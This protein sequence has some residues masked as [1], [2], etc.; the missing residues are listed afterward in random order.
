M[1]IAVNETMEHPARHESG[2]RG[3]LAGL[4]ERFTLGYERR[5]L[6][7]LLLVFVVDYADRT[8]ISSLGPTLERVYHLNNTQLGLV[9]A[10]FSLVAVIVSIPLGMLTDRIRRT[11]LFA[12]TLL[13]WAVAEVFVGAAV[14]FLMFFLVRLALGAVAATT[15]PTTPSMVGDL[16][17]AGERGRAFGFTD[18]GT[19]IGVAVGF[20]LPVIVL[21]FASFRWT[22]WILAVAGAILAF[23]FWRLPEPERTTASGRS[24]GG[25]RGRRGKQRGGD[26]AALSMTQEIVRDEG[27]EPSER[28]VL[29]RDP[30][31]MSVWDAAVYVWHV[32]TD[33]IVLIG[34]SIGDFFFQGIGTFAVVFATAWYGVSQG[35]ADIAILL[36]GVGA[37]I[38]VLVVG[39]LGDALIRR[40]H[41]NSRLWL[42]AIGY[43]LAP[44]ALVPAFL[45]HSLMFALPLF[46]VGAFFLAGSGPPLDAVRIDVL[47]PLLR[48]RAEAIRQV[49]RTLAEGGAPFLI[50]LLS[51]QLFGGGA[52]GLQI[53]FLVTL[54]F[55]VITGLVLLVALRTYQPDVAATYV[56][57]KA[58]QAREQRQ[59]KGQVEGQEERRGE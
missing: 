18:A 55:L 12:V 50:G 40:R 22:F 34:R 32:R 53:A 57:T 31:R 35:Q 51:D 39:R 21:R 41:V 30:S 58:Q 11:L 48:G 9:A 29:K 45:T 46:A 13:I 52:H 49:V 37:L 44:V 5:A 10:A 6:I 15:G 26:D 17:P 19:L 47:V 23:L 4:R 27:I 20:V 7:L 1:G 43:I 59:E 24:G 25:R 42:G 3:L 56:S 33:V 14:S 54:P 28:A 2:S 8:L 36:L 16:V 38:G